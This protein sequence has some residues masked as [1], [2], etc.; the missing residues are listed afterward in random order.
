VAGRTRLG[1]VLQ[2]DPPAATEIDGL[3]RALGDGMLG[4]VAPHVT[5]VTPVNVPAAGLGDAL[6]VLRAAAAATPAPLRLELG[7]ATTFHPVTPVVYLAVGGDLD[8]LESLRQ[9]VVRP[10]LARTMTH[11]FVPHVT[12]ADDMEVAR[13]P[14]AVAAL[15]GYRT[16]VTVDRLHLLRETPGRIWRPIADMPFGPPAIVARGGLPLELTTSRLL[17]PVAAALLAT[18]E[19]RSREPGDAASPAAV[20]APDAVGPAAGDARDVI[21]PGTG[22]GRDAVGTAAGG[23]PARAPAGSVRDSGLPT[24]GASAAGNLGRGGPLAATSAELLGDV[25]RWAVTARRDGEPVGVASGAV[26]GDRLDV[27]A[28]VVAPEHRGQ[29]IGRH[30]RAAVQ[31][32]A[33]VRSVAWPPIRPSSSG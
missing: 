30:L 27:E 8:A 5:L 16:E 23:P 11:P 7:P 2:V 24:A 31:H 3:R 15:A 19:P 32:F 28:L 12:I 18:G 10:P 21:G 13:I 22:D 9:Q 33:G 6:A 26:V 25:D 17:D 14:A 1:V 4:R 29:G 20:H